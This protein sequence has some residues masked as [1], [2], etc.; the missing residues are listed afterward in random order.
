M[1]VGPY[2]PSDLLGLLHQN[3]SNIISKNSFLFRIQGMS[4][5]PILIL[6]HEEY[7]R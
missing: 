1:K 6:R 7:G 2:G 5:G 3:D 4:P